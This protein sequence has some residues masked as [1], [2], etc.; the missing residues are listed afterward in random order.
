MLGKR[1]RGKA[2]HPLQSPPPCYQ[3]SCARPRF[4]SSASIPACAARGGASSSPTAC[5]SRTWRAASSPRTATANWPIAC[6]SSTR[7]CCG[8]IASFKP[9]EAAIEETFVNKD[10]RS[11]LKLGQARGMALLAPAQRRPADCRVC[12]QRHQEDS[13]RRR[14]RREEADPGDD[15][16]PAAEGQVRERGR[17][18]R[19]G[20]R[21]LPRQPSFEPAG[22]CRP[23]GEGGSAVKRPAH[24][25][26]S[27]LVGEG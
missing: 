1:R 7:A 9:Q 16:L 14:P 20:H 19:A 17:G 11:T 3:G 15:R 12:A 13:G 21:H 22:D 4:A 23:P 2:A 24:H 8:V 26:P 10:A 5:G 27:P 18:R 25:V 6:A